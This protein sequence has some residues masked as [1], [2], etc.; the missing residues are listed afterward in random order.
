MIDDETVLRFVGLVA[1]LAIT[2]TALSSG[3]IWACG[4]P[5]VTSPGVWTPARQLP[6]V[7]GAAL[8]AWWGYLFAHY[9]WTDMLIEPSA[10]EDADSYDAIA[11]F[12]PRYRRLGAVI[13]VGT[14]ICGLV[15]GVIFIQ[16]GNHRMANLGTAL[17]L[18][19][20]VFAHFMET[21]ELL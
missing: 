16:A 19:G 5:C 10:H 15:I 7:F 8:V 14:L 9:A 12:H 1:G 4:A 3:F 13:G 21:G 6:L 18:G 11:Q 20:F 17:F 2:A